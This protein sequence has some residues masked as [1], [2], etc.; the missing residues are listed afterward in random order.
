MRKVTQ[1]A[2]NAF[3]QHKKFRRGNTV[4]SVWK[5][6][7]KL[8]LHNNLIAEHH[9]DGRIRI[10]NAGWPTRTTKERLN[11]IPH[12]SIYQRNFQWYLNGEK[13]NGNW[14]EVTA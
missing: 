12:V 11:A 4:V 10:S 2:V 14:I 7:A 6:Y 5:G 8:Y 3:M 9:L 1:D 13:W